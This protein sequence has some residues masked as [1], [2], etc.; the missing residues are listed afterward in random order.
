MPKK[1]VYFLQNV[2]YLHNTLFEFEKCQSSELI[3]KGTLKP[4]L[5]YS[6]ALV[7]PGSK[8]GS[9][10]RPEAGVFARTGAN[11][12]FNLFF[13][14]ILD[15]IFIP[16]NT[17]LKYFT[18]SFGHHQLQQQQQQQLQQQQQQRHLFRS[19]RNQKE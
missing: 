8:L 5:P 1:S 18:F 7:T 19:A 3:I 13:S 10:S 16:S 9:N 4:K 2:A 14:K 11:L 6:R 12:G 15:Q 17:S